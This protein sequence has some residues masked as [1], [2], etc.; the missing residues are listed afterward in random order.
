[1]DLENNVLP[2]QKKWVTAIR[3]VANY[4]RSW[5]MLRCR[6]SF[7]KAHL[8]CSGIIRIPTSTVIWSPHKDVKLGN[9]V[10]FGPR[11]IIQCDLEI[12]NHVLIASCVSFIGHDDH[13]TYIPGKTIWESG[14]G[15]SKKTF[16][17]NDVWIGHG[18]V[19]VAG[20][21]I[22]DGAIIAAGSVVVK[23]VEPCTIVGGNPAHI[24]KNRFNT[25][26]EKI[27][28]LKYLKFI[29]Y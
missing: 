15:D 2:G 11:C 20:V 5:Y 27:E 9:H 7:V 1:M 6:Y 13:I 19:I 17:G 18:A 21:T 29:Y 24:I 16:V 8:K 10:Q 12:G 26:E 25:E 23:N 22:G 4:I 3:R 14:R 28:H